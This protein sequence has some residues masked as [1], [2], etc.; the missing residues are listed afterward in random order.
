[1]SDV[2][3][4]RPL[5]FAGFPLASWAF[6]FRVWIA[7]VVALYVAFWLQ[8]EA[9]S[10]AAVCVGILAFPTRGQA[11]EKAGF[12]FLATAIG[13][14]VS[15]VL[16]GAFSQTR[17]L[18][19]LAFAVWVGMCVY[20]AYVSD[21]NRA[22][23]AV[24]SGYTV[25]IVAIQEIDAPQHLFETGIA[26]GAAITVGI[27]VIAV[28]NDLL[29]APDRHVGLASQLANLH[30][31]VR[32]FART[33]TRGEPADPMSTAGLLRE[34]TALRSEMLS[35][36][37]ES[38][39]GSNRSAAARDAAVALVAEVHAA[40][41]LSARDVV[42]RDR[43]AGEA[44]AALASGT[45]PAHAWRTP[46]Y[47]CHRFA[48]EAGVRATLWLAMASAVFVLAGWSA[49]A[50]SLTQV[51]VVIGL[52]ATAPDPRRFTLMALIAGMI[53]VLCAG[54]LEF[55]VLDGV[56]QFPL[57]AL[58]LAPFVVGPALLLTRP[59]AA[60][61]A[62]GRLIL[63]NTIVILGPSNPQS[64]N[65][66]TFLDVSL[67]VCLAPVLVVAA[68]VLIPPVTNEYRRRW[69]ID[70][71]RRELDCLSSPERARHAPEEAMFRDAVRIGQIAALGAPA[72]QLEEVLGLFDQAGMIRLREQGLAR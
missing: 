45:R 9:A 37:T 14:A 23:A 53:A 47:R 17:D 1:M 70:S 58:A 39:S 27:A 54:V 56:T 3:V 63:V 67:F 72:A 51:A 66:E 46:L 19:L 8:L 69:M 48:V 25:A 32:D 43:E 71:A 2:T 60:V 6:A 20:A 49:A 33:V 12:R 52:G 11:L 22:Y 15:I 42:R 34:I 65:P 61:S 28:V 68:Q 36:V 44:L 10:S 40:R 16:A 30:R 31:R 26:R 38:A 57:L 29:A 50:V 7:V 18:L 4:P 24:L 41:A 21:G 13:V 62:A 35:L 55:L 64:Y 59:T 5:I